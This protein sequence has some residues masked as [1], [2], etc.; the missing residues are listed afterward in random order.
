M[1][2]H[3]ISTIPEKTGG[4]KEELFSKFHK[5][6]DPKIREELIL[7]HSDLV[8]KLASRFTNK[9]KSLDSLVSVGTIGLINAVDRYDVSRGVKFTTYATHCILGEIKR[10]FRDKTWVLKVP[11]SFKRL[12]SIVQDTIEDLTASLGRSPTIS[13]IAKE[14]DIPSETVIEVMEAGRSY[15]PFSLEQRLEFN[16]GDGCS[17]LDFLS[18][19]DQGF[20]NLFDKVDLKEATATLNKREQI[21]VQ[22]FYFEGYSQTKIAERLN[23]SQMHVSRLLRGAIKSLKKILV[24]RI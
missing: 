22:L 17:F 5:T 23:I 1:S 13:E 6:R 11:R 4:I 2:F 14:L 15:R 7:Q 12:N 19:D 10:F 18:Q 24:E 16:D 21:I 9:G 8:R 20:R 3:Q